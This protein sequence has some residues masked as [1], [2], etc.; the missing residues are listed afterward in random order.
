MKRFAASLLAV[1]AVTLGAC[2]PAGPSGSLTV[3]NPASFTPGDASDVGR[4]FKISEVGLGPNGWVTL[5]NYTDTAASLETLFLCQANGCVDLPAYVVA[6]GAAARVAV[7]D[8]KGLENVAMTSADLH[9]P[10]QEGEI[11]LFSTDNIADP[12]GLRTYLEWGST[13]HA[14]TAMAIRNGIWLDGSYAPTAADATRLFQN[15][16]GLWLFDD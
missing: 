8:G 9:L 5:V 16:S 6:G 4:F 14:I 7:G 1:L 15:D 13:P 10:P 3:Q 12:K 2:G 11:A